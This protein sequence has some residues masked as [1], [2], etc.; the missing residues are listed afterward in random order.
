[1][2]SCKIEE[3]IL[4]IEGLESQGLPLN[5]LYIMLSQTVDLN[6]NIYDRVGVYT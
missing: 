1:M 4:E 5:W 6:N 2:D 3:K